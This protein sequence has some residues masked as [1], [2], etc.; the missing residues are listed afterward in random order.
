MRSRSGLR[1]A[2]LLAMMLGPVCFVGC[3][4]VTSTGN[5]G[6]GTGGTGGVSATGGKVGAS[7]G[8]GGAAAAG[9][10]GAGG[11]GAGSD[12]AAGHAGS[13][14]AGASQC[15]PTCTTG[16]LCCEE[17]LHGATDGPRTQWICVTTSSTTICPAFP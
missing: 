7:G 9:H 17:P 12:G 10:S 3:G 16:Q 4:N 8:A 2:G 1:L 14:G 11:G 6:G 5:D 15:V 13:G